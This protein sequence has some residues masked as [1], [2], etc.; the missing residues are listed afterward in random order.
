MLA[1]DPLVKIRDSHLFFCLE[2]G[3]TSKTKFAREIMEEAS[4]LRDVNLTDEEKEELGRIV[5]DVRAHLE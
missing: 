3:D 2:P 5:A 1:E 4:N